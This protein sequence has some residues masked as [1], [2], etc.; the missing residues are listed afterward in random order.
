MSTE[1]EG[2]TTALITENKE[3]EDNKQ[4]HEHQVG[5]EEEE[6]SPKSVPH[7]NESESDSLNKDNTEGVQVQEL[8]EQE[9]QQEEEKVIIT[10]IEK[11][12]TPLGA[13]NLYGAGEI[14]DLKSLS[15]APAGVA[16]HAANT[17]PTC[18]S[19]TSTPLADVTLPAS[20][21]AAVPLL[22]ADADGDPFTVA[23]DATA[24][25]SPAGSLVATAHTPF[26]GTYTFTASPSF[27]GASLGFA[28]TDGT[29]G[30]APV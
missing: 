24:A 28:A 14:N 17:P 15:A 27:T 5:E 23:P 10:N 3:V 9:P 4:P 21:A 18:L 2:T 1:E 20:A 22:C 12:A 29:A 30:S 11:N 7:N 13:H 6:E 19:P 25:S 16:A 26:T 8:Q